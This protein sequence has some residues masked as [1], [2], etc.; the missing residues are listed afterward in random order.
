MAAFSYD[1]YGASE[2]G[3]TFAALV[4]WGGAILSLVLIAGTGNLGLEALGARRDAAYR[5][6]GLWKGR[7]GWHRRNRADRQAIIRG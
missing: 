1:D 4:N 3:G 7:C 2:E 5:W 6:C